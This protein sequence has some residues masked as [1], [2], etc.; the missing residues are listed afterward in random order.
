MIN[1]L[2]VLMSLYDTGD[3]VLFRASIFAGLGVNDY[4]AS[5]LCRC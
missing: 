5:I 4:H 1:P 2:F 3:V